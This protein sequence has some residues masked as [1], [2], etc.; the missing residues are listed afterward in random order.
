MT[1][2][3]V[4]ALK[5]RAVEARCVHN[6]S[7]TGRIT[8]ITTGTTRRAASREHAG[9]LG[10]HRWTAHSASLQANAVL[11]HK[12]WT[13][14]CLA[15]F[16]APQ[17][18]TSRANSGGKA[19][20]SSSLGPARASDMTLKAT[21]G[22]RWRRPNM[23]N[24]IFCSR[25][26]QSL[27]SGCTNRLGPAETSMAAVRDGECTNTRSRL[28]PA[29]SRRYGNDRE[30]DGVKSRKGPSPTRRALQLPGHSHRR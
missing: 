21:R 26:Q 11:L 4:A 13:C 27:A 18:G 19:W 12:N 8:P 16:V 20:V 1:Y 6:A 9:G 14:A 25:N 3:V 10:H 29:R 17:S 2:L 15:S 30:D 5:G 24:S 22:V 23:H 28:G 7:C